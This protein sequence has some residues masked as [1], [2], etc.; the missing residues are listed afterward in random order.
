MW[1][2][3]MREEL[4]K[5][6]DVVVKKPDLCT[7]EEIMLVAQRAGENPEDLE[8]Q[9]DLLDFDEDTNLLD[10]DDFFVSSPYLRFRSSRGRHF[11]TCLFL[12]YLQEWWSEEIDPRDYDEA[13]GP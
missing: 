2:D 8:D 10:W 13:G 1:T 12:P 11:T 6:F 9:I 5:Y 7:R 3:E 4:K